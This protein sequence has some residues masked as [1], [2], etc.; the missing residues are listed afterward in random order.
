MNSSAA[1]LLVSVIVASALSVFLTGL[2][3][4]VGA[5]EAGGGRT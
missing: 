5:H 1:L 4:A 3:F 2:V